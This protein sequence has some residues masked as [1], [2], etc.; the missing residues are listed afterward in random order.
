MDGARTSVF[1]KSHLLCGLEFNTETWPTNMV[2][3]L[4][5][6]SAYDCQDVELVTNEPN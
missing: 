5:C 3:Y 1:Q 2:E 6:V 4:Q